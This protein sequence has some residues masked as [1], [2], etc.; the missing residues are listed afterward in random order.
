MSVEYRDV[1]SDDGVEKK[2]IELLSLAKGVKLAKY[3]NY[4]GKD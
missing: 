4:S 2:S 3:P 1:K